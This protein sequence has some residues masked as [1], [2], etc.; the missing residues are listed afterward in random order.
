MLTL[1][2]WFCS[3]TS[4]FCQPNTG[5]Y[6]SKPPDGSE[7]WDL[8]RMNHIILHHGLLGAG[9]ALNEDLE[10]FFFFPSIYA[11]V[12]SNRFILQGAEKNVACKCRFTSWLNF[13]ASLPTHSYYLFDPFTAACSQSFLDTLSSLLALEHLSSFPL[14]LA[15]V[16]K[17]WTTPFSSSVFSSFRCLR[18]S[19]TARPSYFS[20]SHTWPWTYRQVEPWCNVRLHHFILW[21]S[22][23]SCR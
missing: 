4:Q 9:Q 12:S 19:Q 10:G 13:E 22:G 6:V 17:G 15:G 23:N 21:K 18:P 11:R 14:K 8:C 7:R 5:D 20:F 2:T 1:P 3:S 16:S